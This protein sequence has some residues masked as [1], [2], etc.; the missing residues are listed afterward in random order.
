MGG[1]ASDVTTKPENEGAAQAAAFL[2]E[3]ILNESIEPGPGEGNALRRFGV[4]PRR[5]PYKYRKKWALP[6]QG[7]RL[8]G[9]RIALGTSHSK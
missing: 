7:T 2:L 4:V 3:G 8:G 9:V 1:P 6:Y 5:W